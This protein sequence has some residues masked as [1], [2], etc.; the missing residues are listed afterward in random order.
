MIFIPKQNAGEPRPMERC[1]CDIC[2]RVLSPI[3]RGCF[4]D[5]ADTV[6]KCENFI[7]KISYKTNAA[8]SYLRFVCVNRCPQ[9]CV[10]LARETAREAVKREN[11]KIQLFETRRMLRI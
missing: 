11:L 7:G 4:F 5:L 1:A 6:I 10:S 9:P 2:G 3:N 8:L